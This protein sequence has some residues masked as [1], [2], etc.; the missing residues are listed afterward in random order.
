MNIAELA[1]KLHIPLAELR[2]ILPKAGF[3][4]GMRAVKVDDHTAHKII[5]NWKQIKKD[6]ERIKREEIGP[7]KEEDLSPEALAKEGDKKIIKIPA[8]ITVREF[9]DLLQI[10]ITEVI[11]ELM[12]NGILASVNERIDYESAVIVAED[13]NFKVEKIEKKD[14]V[15]EDLSAQEKL[16]E[17]LKKEAATGQYRPPVV[18]VLGHVDHG[19]TKLLDQIRKTNIVA[20]EAGGI[21]QHIGAYQA[22][23]KGKK[24]TFIDTPGHE[25]FTVMRS[26]GAR[27]ADI[28]IIVVA[29]DDGVQP[30]TI[31]VVKIIQAAKIPFV[32]A[33]NKI[34][35]EG[36][37]INRVKSGLSELGLVPEDWG[38]KTICVPISAKEG[39][40]IDDLLGMI[41][42][43][44]DMEKEKIAANPERPAIGTIIESHIDKGEGVVATVLVQNGTL[45]IND[46]LS[47]GDALYGRVRA[48]RDWNGKNVTQAPPSM[49]VKILGFKVAPQVGDILE[50]PEDAK[51][52]KFKKVKGKKIAIGMP[53]LIQKEEKEGEKQM[54]NL[55]LK[56]DML[57]SLEALIGTIDKFSHTDVG[58]KII[59]KGLGNITDTD[60]LSAI[61]TEKGVFT[62]GAIVYGFNVNI[63][64]QAAELAHD[65]G[66]EVRLYKVIY[67]L[68]DNL[69]LEM[70][71]LL[72]PERHIIEVAKLKILA[73]FKVEK[74]QVIVGGLVTEGKIVPELKARIIR[75]KKE[76]GSGRI[77]QV[78]MGKREVKEA[79]SGS[80]CGLS[81][82]IR[83]TIIEEGDKLELYTEEVKERKLT[84]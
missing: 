5:N 84:L 41:L 10:S 60:V 13:L 68:L 81:I 74:N 55:V 77:I 22:E 67:D 36:A 49:P 30:Q 39:R 8:I 28:A 20:G 79:P 66:V 19:K 83:D 34:D 71:K 48:M 33:I 59:S 76:V 38:G 72:I 64:P 50:I 63:T 82:Q 40:N 27:V 47:V 44:A 3:D 37:D 15:K 52:L 4:I 54:V 18:V 7:E 56:T 70:E 75:D 17:L 43:V 42:L 1:R 16:K 2:E 25:A 58:A 62:G 73:I 78:Q 35:R 69:K 65:K 31:E 24:I 14:D 32:V 11:K 6:Y 53:Q 46:N 80:E 51:G 12:K 26:R 61:S 9:A 57:G 23:E 29:A 45:K 21:T